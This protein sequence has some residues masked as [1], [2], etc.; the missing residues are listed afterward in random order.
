[1]DVITTKENNTFGSMDDDHDDEMDTNS[2][3]DPIKQV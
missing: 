1:M 2:I 3:P